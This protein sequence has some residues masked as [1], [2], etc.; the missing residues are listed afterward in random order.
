[1]LSFCTPE[2]LSVEENHGVAIAG[3][4]F[5]YLYGRAASIETQVNPAKACF[6]WRRFAPCRDTQQIYLVRVVWETY[7]DD[8]QG[9]VRNLVHSENVWKIKWHITWMKHARYRLIC[10]LAESDQNHRRSLVRTP[11]TGTV[12]FSCIAS[13]SELIYQRE[14]LGISS[15]TVLHSEHHLSYPGRLHATSSFERVHT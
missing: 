13:I 14:V 8:N 7:G 6:E 3:C 15:V 2:G 11:C 12:A 5:V 9:S 10:D 4:V 1:M